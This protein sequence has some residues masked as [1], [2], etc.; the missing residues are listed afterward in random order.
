MPRAYH[1]K[2]PKQN[3]QSTHRK[4]IERISWYFRRSMSSHVRISEFTVQFR[5]GIIINRTG[6]SLGKV[7]GGKTRSSTV[8]R[9]VLLN[10]R[11]NN[12]LARWNRQAFDFFCQCSFQQRLEIF[13]PVLTT[14]L[15]RGS[16]LISDLP[17]KTSNFLNDQFLHSFDTILLLE[18]EVECLYWRLSFWANTVADSA[19]Y[20]GTARLIGRIMPDSKVRV[21]NGLL[22]TDSSDGVKL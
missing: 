2:N 12:L 19:T 6:Q 13:S 11:I 1:S 16:C 8:E 17:S 7:I 18:A 4:R 15:R 21:T 10:W 5:T 3:A 14:K 20:R 22:A 9:A